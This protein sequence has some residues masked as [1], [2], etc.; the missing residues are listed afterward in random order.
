PRRHLTARG[1]RVSIGPM[2]T[3]IALALALIS[4]TTGCSSGGD[5]TPAD[6]QDVTGTQYVSIVDFKDA[7][8]Q[9]AWYDLGSKLKQ[10]FG[11]VCGDTFCAG[12]YANL[13][14]LTFSCSVS[15]KLGNVHDCVWTF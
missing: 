11:A 7:S 15:S 10:E 9:G 8:L 4:A 12:D 14:P 3:R 5:P 2:K 13:T 1:A 6:E